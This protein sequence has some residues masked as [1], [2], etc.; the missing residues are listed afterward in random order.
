MTG[1][2]TRSRCPSGSV[3]PWTI[4]ISDAVTAIGIAV[5]VVA[6]V[7]GAGRREVAPAASPTRAVFSRLSA[8]PSHNGAYRASLVP[9]AHTAGS[10]SSATWTVEVRTANDAPVEGAALSVESWMPDDNLVPATRPRVTESL[11]GGQYRVEGLELGRRGWWNVRL[12]I[13]ARYGTDSL[14]FN[15]VR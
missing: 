1:Q 4:H 5:M 2:M 9:S 3:A 13:S 10:F 11:G 15:L 14:A 8:I 12:Q 7:A 6:L